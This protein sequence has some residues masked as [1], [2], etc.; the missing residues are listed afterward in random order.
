MGMYW[1]KQS[2]IGEKLRQSIDNGCKL[3]VDNVNTLWKAGRY[4][5]NWPKKQGLFTSFDFR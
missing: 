4:T 3:N 1:L 2:K 5:H